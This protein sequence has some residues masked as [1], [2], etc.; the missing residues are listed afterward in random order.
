[1]DRLAV[2]D[3][4]RRLAELERLRILDTP[5]EADFDT[6][7][8]LGAAILR[9]PVAA[10]N[11]VDGERHYTK[12]VVGMP[13]AA[14]GSVP[15]DL[16]LCAATIS[17]H[18]GVLVVEDT[19]ADPHWSDHDLVVGGPEVGFYAGVAVASRGERVGVVCA[20][21]SKPRPVSE[22]E[23]AA[24][25]ALAGQAG[26]QLEL[27]AHAAELREMAVTDPLTRLP[28]RELLMDRL[29]VALATRAEPSSQ[30]GVLFCDVD[31]FKVIN[32]TLGHEAGDRVLCHVAERLSGAMRAGDT[33]GRMAG[34]EFVV[35]C[36]QLGGQA[37]LD[38]LVARI[39]AAF[40]EPSSVGPVGVSVGAILA[41]AGE[42]P[43]D[44]LRRADAAMYADKAS[45][46]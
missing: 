39:D 25:I 3:D 19:H 22:A 12:A 33:V 41:R 9:S 21:G 24:L 32:D 18:D 44:V 30:V 5:P 42:D 13:E 10:V 11:F 31:A 2:L 37:E 45:S 15:N 20:F 38:A 1:M 7:A 29:E 28:N 8:M 16:S 17:T 40:A 36:P 23:R 34:D 26:A 14:G 6:I 4:P 43:A 27:R 35:V 46:G